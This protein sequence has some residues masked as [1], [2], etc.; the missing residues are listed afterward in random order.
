MYL[1]AC[2]PVLVA[3]FVL[4]AG[5]SSAIT[6]HAPVCGLD[7]PTVDPMSALPGDAV[8]LTTRPVT[9]EW[10]T[11]VMIG[12]VLAPVAK[13]ERDNCDDCDSCVN[14]TGATC[15]VCNL[16]C[17]D[18]AEICGTCVQRVKITVPDMA[19]G[20]WPVVVTNRHGQ[21][22]PASLTV[23]GGDTGTSKP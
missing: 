5:C 14:D 23:L 9:E 18:C 16:S 12:S 17:D 11:T 6:S 1:S 13:V 2:S 21:S 8:W 15:D 7:A 4:L 19:P 10:D 3:L 22:A 20:T